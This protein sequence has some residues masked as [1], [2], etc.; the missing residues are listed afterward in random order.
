MKNLFRKLLEKEF[1]EHQYHR[2]AKQMLLEPEDNFLNMTLTW[3]LSERLRR[4]RLLELR[5]MRE[6]LED[7]LLRSYRISRGYWPY[8]VFCLLSMLLLFFLVTPVSAGCFSLAGIV[9]CY[10]FRTKEYVTNKYCYI[11]AKL[12][13]CYRIALEESLREFGGCGG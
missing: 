6:R 12:I 13:L 11:D 9:A 10:G 4:K 2:M 1:G 7:T 5:G 8:A 3:E